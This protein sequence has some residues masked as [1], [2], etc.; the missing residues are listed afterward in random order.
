MAAPGSFGLLVGKA[1]FG[2]DNRLPHLRAA[3]M[4][5]DRRTAPTRHRALGRRRIF[6]SRRMASP[7]SSKVLQWHSIIVVTM[8]R[9]SLVRTSTSSSSCNFV[10][11]IVRQRLDAVV[12]VPKSRNNALISRMV[13]PASLASFTTVSCFKT[14]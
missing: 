14:E 6:L 7:H 9:I 4:R 10:A 11:A 8:S 12:S 2:R 1:V 3:S 5:G 13:I